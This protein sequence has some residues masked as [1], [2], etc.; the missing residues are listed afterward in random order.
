VN[1]TFVPKPD[2]S[3]CTEFEAYQPVS[4]L[5]FLLK[6]MEKSVDGYIMDYIWG[7]APYI[8]TYLPTKLVNLLK[9][10]FTE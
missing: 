8:Q 4:L 1:A 2:K 5:S 6:M 7:I 3:G 9:L 10:H